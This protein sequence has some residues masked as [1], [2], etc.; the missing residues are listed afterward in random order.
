MNNQNRIS[1]NANFINQKLKDSY[2]LEPIFDSIMSTNTYIKENY[3]QLNHGSIII[4]KHQ[5][6]G[7][8]RFNRT[9]ESNDDVGIYCSFLLKDNLNKNIL[10]YINLKIAC[11][12]HHSIK[13]CFKIETQ[14]KWPNDLIINQKKCAGILIES[15]INSVTNQYNCLII[16]WGLNVYNQDFSESLRDSATTLEENS[17]NIL[18]RNELIVHFFNNLS[19]FLYKVDIVEYYKQFMIPIG[20]WVQLSINRSKELVKIIDI[21]SQG[22]LIVEKKD[23]TLLTLYNEEILM[24]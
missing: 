8:G 9:F 19:H 12:L 3:A 22:Q 5:K 11:A 7:R 4:S 14:I 13:Q 24:K 10:D 18:D 21:N 15:Q 16:G 6:S 2:L 23:K 17:D 20:T 1:L